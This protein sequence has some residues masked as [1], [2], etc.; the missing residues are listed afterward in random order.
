MGIKKTQVKAGSPLP[1]MLRSVILVCAIPL[2][3]ACSSAPKNPGDV[4]DMRKQAESQL[5]LGNKQSDRGNNDDALILLTEAQRLARACDDSSLI[6]RTSLSRGNVLLGLGKSADASAEFDTALAE[7][8]RIGDR[9]LSAVS[10]I[11]M[12][13]YQLLMGLAPAQNLKD[14][15]ASERAN[16][17]TEPLYAAFAWTVSGLI[18]KEMGY[19]AGAEAALKQALAI[20]EKGRYLEQAAYDWFLIASFR[21]QDKNYPLSREALTQS[22]TLDRRVENSYGLASDWRALG[23]IYAK[24]GNSAESKT[25]Y[26]R[27]AVIFRAQGNDEAALEAESRIK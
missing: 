20:H 23:D 22:L 1:A 14:K 7:A 11:H 3:A 25:A 5:D 9:E 17:K 21:S 8:Q 27:S 19:F 16:I 18:E 4:F 12:Y 10:R 24:E 26:M 6:I 2:F 15:T 13:R